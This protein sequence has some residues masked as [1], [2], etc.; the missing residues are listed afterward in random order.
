MNILS[1][2]LTIIY[3]VAIFC[4]LIFAHEIGH[5]SAAKATGVRVNEFAL[6]M[7]P[8]LLKFRKG[9]TEYTLRA[10]PIGGF[11]AMEGEDADSEDPK[12]F[13]K[14]NVAQKALIIVA[15]ASMNFLL[16]LV[17]LS[18][19]AFT[20]GVPTNVIAQ[21]VPDTP[22]A[23]AGLL[24]GDE[25]IGVDGAAVEG[26]EQ[27]KSHIG[28][29]GER[30]ELEILRDG[31]ELSLETG[32]YLDGDGARKIGFNPAT[33]VE[34]SDFLPSLKRGA[35]A[36][37]DMFGLILYGLKMLFTGEASVKDLTGPVGIVNLMG[38]AAQNGFAMLMRLTAFISLNLAIVNML[39]L[40]ALDGGRLVFL[41]I[42]KI[43]GRRF[44][45]EMEGRVHLVGMALLFGLMAFVLVQDIARAALGHGIW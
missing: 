15:G 24:P 27:M 4:L 38:Q 30:V 3:G 16:A 26:W 43:A 33:K 2:A 13:N 37:G 25:I 31:Q 1:I 23:E 6:G 22:A 8:K 10:F 18:V 41:I 42:R 21:V 14:K 19:V 40:P 28:K 11:C 12:A 7:G 45:D 17:I 9:D 34:A 44:T 35:Q 29:A 5:F 36:T 20:N 32:S 39:P